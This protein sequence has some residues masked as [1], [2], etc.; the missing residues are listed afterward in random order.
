MF[1]R[2][3]I[4]ILIGFTVGCGFVY[5]YVW[6]E[7]VRQWMHT[8]EVLLIGR[9]LQQCPDAIR[10]I[11]W[12][13]LWLIPQGRERKPSSQ[14]CS[15]PLLQLNYTSH[16]LCVCDGSWTLKSTMHTCV[17]VVSIFQSH[18]F[19]VLLCS[20]LSILSCLYS[21]SKNVGEDHPIITALLIE[22]NRCLRSQV[23]SGKRRFVKQDC[24]TL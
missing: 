16:D 12:C 24:Y 11:R 3:Q 2:P 1:P 5:V 23:M 8:Q 13:C 19:P 22:L 20:R 21:K 10:S 6:G 17:C 15:R 18:H 9:Q 14:R 4:F 7:S